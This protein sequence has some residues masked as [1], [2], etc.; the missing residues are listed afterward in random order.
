MKK[1]RKLL[2]FRTKRYTY[3]LGVRLPRMAGGADLDTFQAYVTISI[4]KTVEPPALNEKR[5]QETL[6]GTKLLAAKGEEVITFQIS[7]KEAA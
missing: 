3:M 7:D 2:Q 4:A 1:L 6:N 5:I